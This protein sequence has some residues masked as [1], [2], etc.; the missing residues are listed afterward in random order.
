MQS[1]YHISFDVETSL[2]DNDEIR[3]LVW[4]LL[5]IGK[6]ACRENPM[7]VPALKEIDVESEF[8]GEPYQPFRLFLL[9][10]NN[11]AVKEDTVPACCS[12]RFRELYA[13]ISDY[14]AQ[15]KIIAV[16]Y[17]PEGTKLLDGECVYS[18]SARSG[19]YKDYGFFRKHP[20]LE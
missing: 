7:T 14:I 6:Q 18:Y 5:K 9:P 2:E 12:A 20:E 10:S 16:F 3:A 17:V 13:S 1:L 11:S 15:G 4:T 8:C 19:V